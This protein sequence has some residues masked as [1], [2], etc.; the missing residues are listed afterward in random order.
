MRRFTLTWADYTPRPS[1]ATDAPARHHFPR[2]NVAG[3]RAYFGDG[4][5]DATELAPPRPGDARRDASETEF[6]CIDVSYTLADTVF[7]FE[8]GEAD[9]I[10]RILFPRIAFRLLDDGMRPQADDGQLED[11]ALFS[12]P[13]AS[14][15]GIASLFPR[16]TVNAIETSELRQWEKERCLIDYTDCVTMVMSRAKPH[17]GTLKVRVGH[18]D[19]SVMVGAMCVKGY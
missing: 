1:C 3:T 9:E 10:V 18:E 19:G 6:A 14:V 17:I 12:I 5:V 11:N 4:I 7:T 8:I 2:V 15:L 16:S 13:G